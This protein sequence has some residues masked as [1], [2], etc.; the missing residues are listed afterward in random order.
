MGNRPEEQ[1]FDLIILIG[2]TSSL[3]M[4]FDHQIDSMVCIL[5]GVN[6]VTTL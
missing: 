2:N 6:V 3:G 5:M 4:L 1:V